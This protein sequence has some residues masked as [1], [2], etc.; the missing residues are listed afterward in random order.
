M[1]S[2][3]RRNSMPCETESHLTSKESLQ[4]LAEFLQVSGGPS[5]QPNR[6]RKVTWADYLMAALA[7]GITIGFP[8]WSWIS[9]MH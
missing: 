1:T 5:I 2:S 3:W 6:M 7:V 9:R 8:I 4:R